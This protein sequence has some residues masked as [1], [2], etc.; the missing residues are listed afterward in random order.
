MALAVGVLD[1]GVVGSVVGCSD[2]DE[3][4]AVAFEEMERRSPACGIHY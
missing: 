3:I 4:V 2:E 1:V